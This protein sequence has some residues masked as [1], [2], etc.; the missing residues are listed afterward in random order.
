V[1]SRAEP[2]RHAFEF[3]KNAGRK[4]LDQWLFKKLENHVAAV[5]LYVAHYNLCRVHEALKMTPAKAIGVAD[6]VWAIGDLI[7]AAL[8]TQ[9]ITPVP[10]ASE[11]RKQ[12]MV[13]EGGRK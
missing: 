6:R 13:I 2:G 8:A 11:R 3:F 1:P 9:P 4:S 10:T 12:F 7:D 5:A